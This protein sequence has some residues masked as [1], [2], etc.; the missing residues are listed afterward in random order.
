M[1]LPAILVV[2]GLEQVV[3]ADV[4]WGAL[5]VLMVAADLLLAAGLGAVRG[6]AVRLSLRD[7]YLYRC[8]GGLSLALW[9]VSIGVRVLI[10][11]L[12]DGT[13]AGPAVATTLTLGFGVSIAAQYT[14]LAARVRADGRPI[15][16]TGDRR[17][18]RARVTLDR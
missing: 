15:R 4:R 17:G 7:G 16:P 2:L 12:A 9:A 5:A 18:P 8:G 11:V 6:A 13:S 3:T 1:V 14:V 10:S